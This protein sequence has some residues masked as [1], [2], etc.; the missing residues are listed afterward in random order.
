MKDFADL[1]LR[2]LA[3]MAKL[4]M[5]G[6]STSDVV[7]I[8]NV[9]FAD[10]DDY[11]TRLMAKPVK[12][13]EVSRSLNMRLKTSADERGITPN[14]LAERIVMTVMEDQ[15]VPA[16]LND[17][18]ERRSSVR[19]LPPYLRVLASGE[20]KNRGMTPNL[21]V[22]QILERVVDNEMIDKVL[23]DVGDPT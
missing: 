14:A 5:E 17:P 11:R 3:D 21:F 12:A 2:Q 1:T 6:C 9:S 13:M 16:I 10:A 20:A 22:A 19:H 23:D 4:F 7:D 18:P 15:M 8:Y